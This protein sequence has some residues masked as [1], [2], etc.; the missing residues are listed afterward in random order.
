MTDKSHHLKRSQDQFQYVGCAAPCA[1]Y[2]LILV[3]TCGMFPQESSSFFR[4]A[5]ADKRI[6]YYENFVNKISQIMQT[7]LPS[8][9][10]K[11]HKDRFRSRIVIVAF[12][13]KKTPPL[14]HPDGRLHE[15]E[16]VQAHVP[17]A[18]ISRIAYGLLH[19]RISDV[20]SPVLR[21]HIEPLQ[22]AD[23]P[24]KPRN[25]R[26]PGSLSVRACQ[27]KPPPGQAVLFFHVQKLCVQ[28]LRLEAPVCQAHDK[29][30]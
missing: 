18:D 30:I 2:S 3:L 25:R 4:I 28:M 14:I 6:P 26:T 15:R 24:I 11:L 12:N 17:V 16:R 7:A 19:Q 8:E 10:G 27:I 23:L 29:K 22:L 9:K 21:P 13:G 5:P 1:D 20:P